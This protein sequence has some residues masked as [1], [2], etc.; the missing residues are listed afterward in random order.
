MFMYLKARGIHA[1]GTVR[2]RKGYPTEELK[3]G[4]LTKKGQVAWQTSGG[5]TALKWK[6]RKDTFLLSSIHP[7]PAMPDWVNEESASE[8][9]SKDNEERK[10]ATVRWTVKVN[11]QWKS[12]EI[13]I[14]APIK[15]Y[16]S[17]MG[18]VDLCHQMT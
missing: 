13:Y 7:P 8:S 18:R 3:A 14:S 6:D 10:E 15:D 5:M 12:K 16:N 2:N 17:F 1:A 11:G 9:N 4:K